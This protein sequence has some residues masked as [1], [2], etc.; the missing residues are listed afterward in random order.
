M[1]PKTEC[2]GNVHSLLSLCHTERGLVTLVALLIIAVEC[3]CSLHLVSISD[4][5]EHLQELGNQHR[6]SEDAA[7]L[8]PKRSSVITGI[9]EV[10]VRARID[11]MRERN[12]AVVAP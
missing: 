8:T 10:S 1:K 6:P 9:T 3:T 5:R 2:N 7:A 11:G 12:L 4:I